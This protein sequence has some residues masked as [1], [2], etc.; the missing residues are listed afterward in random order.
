MGVQGVANRPQVVAVAQAAHHI[1]HVEAH[2]R[3]TDVP[4]PGVVLPADGHAGA[5]GRLVRAAV[6]WRFGAGTPCRIVGSVIGVKGTGVHIDQIA[7]EEHA[8]IR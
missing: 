8:A 2:R 3:C 4:R 5:V 6:T 7:T 1:D